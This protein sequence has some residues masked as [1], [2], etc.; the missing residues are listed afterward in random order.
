MSKTLSID[1]RIAAIS[2]TTSGFD[3]MRLVLAAAVLLW[4]SHAVVH[5]F[6]AG[7]LIQGTPAGILPRLVLPMFF[8]L[9]GFLVASSLERTR[10]LRVFLTFRAMRILP[11]LA[12]EVA[13][14]SMLIGP[15]VSQVDFAQYL[16]SPVFHRYLLN[17]VGDISFHLP[18]VFL[19]NPWSGIVN[20]SLWT[21]PYELECYI[22]LIV[23]QVSGLSRRPLGPLVV[24]MVLSLCFLLFFRKHS[25]DALAIDPVPGRMLVLSFLAGISL[26][27]AR[28]AIPYSMLLGFVA[29]VVGVA[30]LSQPALQFLAPLP[31]AYV[32]VWLGLRNPP[33]NRLLLG[34]DYSYGLYLYGFV[35]QQGL[36]FVFG[37]GF[38]STLL[39]FAV[40]LAVTSL[41][42]YGSWHMIERPVLRLKRLFAAP[43]GKAAGRP[44]AAPAASENGRLPGTFAPSSV[45]NM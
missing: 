9:S 21:V 16:Q 18:G 22:L 19:T 24:T 7:R 15:L 20:A 26:Q 2:Q 25:V 37:N 31:I 1:G 23:V 33:R 11:A 41:V 45:R 13:L 30:C 40:A 34:G 36:M 32:T 28:R 17:M 12:V 44:D 39:L 29:A 43:Q 38:H 3:Y 27:A 10:S 6:E 14:S 4:H 5:G 42:A 35:V 8:S